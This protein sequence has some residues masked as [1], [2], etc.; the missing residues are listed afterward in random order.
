MIYTEEDKLRLNA[1][2]MQKNVLE[3]FNWKT[4]EIVSLKFS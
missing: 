2:I 4:L 3:S 1:L